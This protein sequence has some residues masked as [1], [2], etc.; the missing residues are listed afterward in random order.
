MLYYN[1]NTQQVISEDE[2]KML[3][4]PLT[5]RLV[6][7]NKGIFQYK[8]EQPTYNSS[9]EM[10][11]PD[12][13]PT[14]MFE[15]QFTVLQKMRVVSIIDNAIQLKLN[16]LQEYRK[17]RCNTTLLL[18]ENILVDTSLD[19]RNNIAATLAGLPE[20]TEN[21]T[22]KAENKWIKIS[23]KEL[24][25]IYEQIIKYIEACFTQQELL[26]TRIKQCTTLDELN[27]I[28]FGDYWPETR[29]YTTPKQPE[30][31]KKE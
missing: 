9:T 22:F 12:G 18:K 8:S 13:I 7:A 15:D 31:I 2:V 26:E 21:I 28:N 4:I 30:R 25:A 19:S 14:P 24:K 11:I 17:I 3:G 5:E 6:L 27:S 1:V 29:F 16:S 20:T 23:Y 10:L